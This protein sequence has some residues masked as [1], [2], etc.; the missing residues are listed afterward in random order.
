MNQRISSRV[1]S[2]KHAFA[3]IWYNL[4]SGPNFLIHIVC[5]I[6]VVVAGWIFRVERNEW[7]ILILTIGAVLSAEA[8]NT[9]VEKICNRF[10]KEKDPYVKIIKDSAAAA[11]LIISLAALV[12]GLL[13]FVPY[14]VELF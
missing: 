1:H 14:L 4:T 7:I 12:I 13:V 8:M 6:L 3:G 2:F 11:V 5:A 10:L 9:A